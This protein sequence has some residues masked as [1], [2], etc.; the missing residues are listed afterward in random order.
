MH[1]R[2]SWYRRMEKVKDKYGACL[3]WSQYYYY[4]TG[5]L[6]QEFCCLLY[7]VLS[8]FILRRKDLSRLVTLLQTKQK[9]SLYHLFMVFILL[10]LLFIQPFGHLLFASPLHLILN[11]LSS[12][13]PDTP[14]WPYYHAQGC[15]VHWPS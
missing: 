10:S 2:F 14:K 3:S 15:S 6:H 8:S 12:P 13:W 7:Y 4:N 1:L 9:H 5:F 11:M